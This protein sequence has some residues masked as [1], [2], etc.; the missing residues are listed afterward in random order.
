[1]YGK[2]RVTTEKKNSQKCSLK[3]KSIKLKG[4]SKYSLKAKESI[5]GEK[6]EQKKI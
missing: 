5:K 6:G 3:K 4:I 1:M 2:P